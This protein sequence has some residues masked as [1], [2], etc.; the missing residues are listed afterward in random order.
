MPKYTVQEIGQYKVTVDVEAD[1]AQEAIEKW[2]CGDY[3]PGEL[4]PD[5]DM[6]ALDVDVI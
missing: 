1:T 4:I 2:A 3:A 6:E 5:W